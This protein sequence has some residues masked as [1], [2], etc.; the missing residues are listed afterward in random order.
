[1]RRL[2]KILLGAGFVIL[3]FIFSPHGEGMREPK[4]QFM[5]VLGGLLLSA[6]VGRRIS[7]PLGLGAAWVYLSCFRAPFFP[8]EALLALSAALGSCLLVAEATENDVKGGLE[9]LQITGLLC[10]GYAMLFQL[11]AADP[12]LRLIPGADYRRV[13]VFFGQHTLYGPFCVACAAPA[14][15]R[16]RL[17]RAI[18]IASPL[19]FINASFTWASAGVVVALYLVFRYGRRAVLGLSLLAVTGA[20]ALGYTYR[21][22]DHTRHEALNDNGRFPLWSLTWTIARVHPWLGRGLGSFQEQFPIFQSPEL[23]KAGG[24]EDEKLSER[25]R[26]VVRRAEELRHRSGVFVHPHN[27]FLLVAYEFGRIGLALTALIILVFFASF[28]I[29][30]KTPE[31]WALCAIFLSALANALGNFNFHLIPQALPPL[32]AFVAMTAAAKRGTL[33]I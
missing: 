21:F 31:H 25:A 22:T 11:A 19:P 1:M 12:L 10:A 9:I 14:L 20:G 29:S 16:G 23:R 15:F 26:D 13:S 2:D 24:V 3:P 33:R 28:W 8:I 5:A 7:W 4:A 17:F 30:K 32:W 6:A 27:E 18:L